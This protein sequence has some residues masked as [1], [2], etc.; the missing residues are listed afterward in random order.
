G[1]SHLETFDPKPSAPI[2]IRGPY[3]TIRTSVPGIQ[4]GSLLPQRSR[5][6]NKCAL[7]RSMTSHNG[8]HSG[9][10]MLSGGNRGASSYGAVLQRL[11]GPGRSGMPPFV[12]VGPPGYL[13]GSGNLGAAFSPLQVADPS[14]QVQLPEFTLT[15]NV[16]PERFNDR[17]ALLG[18]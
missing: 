5:H 4:I 9:S 2:D 15:A 8:D 14:R 6:M 17:R 7:I 18:A 10:T 16:N 12:H 3:G 1:P 13:P 11:Q